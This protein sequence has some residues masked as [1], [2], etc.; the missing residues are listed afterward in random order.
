MSLP[1]F[2]IPDLIQLTENQTLLLDG[3]QTKHIS[4]LRLH[5]GDCLEIIFPNGIWR[6]ELASI[7]NN[8][9]T[10]RLVAPIHEDREAPIKIYAY[11]P[12][13]AQLSLWDEFLPGAVELGTTIF[14]PVIYERSQYN[15]SKVERRMDRW[16][17]IVQSACEQSHRSRIPDLLMPVP[18]ESLHSLDIKQRWVAYELMTAGPNP[19]LT[20]E[21]IAFTHG[22]EGGITDKEI[23]FLVRAGWTPISLGKSI[24]RAATC[25][26]AILGAIQIEL[27][28]QRF[29]T[30]AKS[31]KC[32]IYSGSTFCS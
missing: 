29:H 31:G 20:L 28:R 18:L 7:D 15:K 19:E 2:F 12:I 16:R 23:D 6:G 8:K 10:I 14:Q 1:R 30:I 32:T 26:S 13:T 24:L 5:L 3:A 17:K 4:V 22:P 25:P 11:L 9:A 27:G 21:D